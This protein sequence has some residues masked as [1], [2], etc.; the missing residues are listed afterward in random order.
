MSDLL[1]RSRSQVTVTLEPRFAGNRLVGGKYH[2]GSHTI[3]LYKDQIKEQCCKLFGSTNRLKEYIAVILAHELGHS[4]DV[5]LEQL[6][7]ALEEPLTARQ[8]AEI[9]LRIEE[10]AWHYAA[11]LLADMDTSFLQ[12]IIEESLFSYRRSFELSIA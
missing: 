4:E 11:V 7:L 8:Q 2:M 3:Y 6:A 9:R 12:I 1:G 5:E 10:N